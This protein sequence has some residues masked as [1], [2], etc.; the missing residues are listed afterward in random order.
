MF[1]HFLLG[2]SIVIRFGSVGAI[3]QASLVI[4]DS[5]TPIPIIS[6]GRLF[7]S[8]FEDFLHAGEGGVYAEKLSNRAMAQPF[9][10]TT[11]FRC[12]GAVGT[13]DCT[14]FRESGDIIR[15]S[16]RP[17]N[18][19]VTHAM[20]IEP[21]SIAS[22]A[23]FPGG[24]AVRAGDSL[25]LTL[26]IYVQ[27]GTASLEARL[28]DGM[29]VAGRTLGSVNISQDAATHPKWLQVS[30]TLRVQESS[31]ED[32][33]RFQLINR[34]PSGSAKVGVTVVSL[35]PAQTWLGRPNGLRTD[36]ASW[37]NETQPPFIR[38][39]G[40]C[41]VEGH[42]LSTSGWAW[43]HTLGNIEDRPGHLNDVWGYWTDDGLGMLELLRMADDVGARPLLVVNAGCSTQSCVGSGAALQ[44]YIQDA[45]D[46]V[47]YVTGDSST[48]WGGRR[49]AAGRSEPFELQALGIGNENCGSRTGKDYPHNWYA[50]AS[51]VRAKYPTLP[52]ILGCETQDQMQNMLKEEPRIRQLADLYDVHQRKSPTEFL[53]AAHEFDSYPRT[54]FPKL[55]VSEYSSPRRLFPNSTTLGAAVA[56]AVY[57]AGMEANGDVVA[58]ATYGDLMANS[59]DTHG[60]AGVST[61]LINARQS[62]G[63]PSWAVQKLF[64]HAQPGALVHSTLG[65]S[66]GAPTTGS[67]PGC[68][69]GPHFRPHRNC[70]TDGR[71]KW[72]ARH[73]NITDMAACIAAVSKCKMG[74]FASFYPPNQTDDG[75]CS[76]HLSCAGWPSD[77]ASCP[78]VSSAYV[79]ARAH[80]A[81]N[82]CTK[83]TNGGTCELGVQ[84]GD[85]QDPSM[86]AASVSVSTTGQIIAKLVNYNPNEVSLT[87]QLRKA[88]VEGVLSWISGDSPNLV[89]SF[90]QPRRVSVQEKAVALENGKVVIQ[91]PSWSVSV[92]RITK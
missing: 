88:A 22:N 54:H 19:A 4:D 34:A 57:M 78:T 61:I 52:L 11:S 64:M 5:K 72:N 73:H 28:V 85:A 33:C 38:T 18:S 25:A 90:A 65:V 69:G 31:G 47:E 51:A 49:A 56:E 67:I 24:I 26:F 7:G 89:N 62:Y 37:L 75:G 8:F 71:G 82:Q 63:S 40:G 48:P 9:A 68:C 86:L 84:R 79:S 14:W 55:F 35:F 70:D 46:A 12:S 80:N 27:E 58:L 20:W 6:P 50:I 81:S 36:V 10:K 77:I 13:G 59:A 17:L 42:N 30:A 21:Q 23:G 74:N 53:A 15:D 43:K 16:S 66:T 39:P 76:W 1:A 92:L 29:G 45:L 83:W 41:Y 3:I 32:G 2:I 44:P 87:V 91:L 60:S